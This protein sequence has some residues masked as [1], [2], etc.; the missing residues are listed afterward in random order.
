MA[1]TSFGTCC[2][3]EANCGIV[4]EHENGKIAKI[5]GDDQDAFSRG[6][7]VGSDARLASITSQRRTTHASLG[8]FSS[9]ATPD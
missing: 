6:Y 3:C 1:Q 7:T 8:W 5:S 4:V 2:L 9:V